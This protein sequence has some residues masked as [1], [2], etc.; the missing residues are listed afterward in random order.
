LVAFFR[1]FCGAA[2]LGAGDG[3][4]YAAIV[5]LHDQVC[6]IAVY[7]QLVGLRSYACNQ[8][9]QAMLLL[10]LLLLLL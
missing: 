5:G 10:L 7:D 8:L 9:K 6:F 3:N 4:F 1:C 2:D